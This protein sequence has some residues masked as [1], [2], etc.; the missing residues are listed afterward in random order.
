MSKKKTK[1]VAKKTLAWTALGSYLRSRRESLNLNQKTMAQKLG[2]TSPQIISNIE[3]GV[4]GVPVKKVKAFVKIYKA[5]PKEVFDAYIKVQSTAL[6]KE[7]G[8]KI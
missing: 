1:T 3:R 8:I 2:Y 7:L 4:Q 6:T 5:D